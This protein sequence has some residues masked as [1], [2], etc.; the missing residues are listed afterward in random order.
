M[1]WQLEDGVDS[2]LVVRDDVDAAFVSSASPATRLFGTLEVD[3]AIKPTQY[4]R[5]ETDLTVTLGGATISLTRLYDSFDRERSGSFG[6]GWSL[7]GQD[8]DIQ[9]SVPPSGREGLGVYNPFRQGTR[10]YLTLPDGR[11]VGF[12]F[13][14]RRHD[15]P[16]ITSYTP[17]FEA[18]TGVSRSAMISLTTGT[19]VPRRARSTNSS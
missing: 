10:V 8:A 3:T 16:G 4:Q 19:N 12:T 13:T 15:A 14:P 7:A 11:R 2:D 18:D 6:Y 1:S 5:S 17:A 9:T